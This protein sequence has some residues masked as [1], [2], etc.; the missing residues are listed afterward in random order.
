[1]II[2]TNINFIA[3]LPRNRPKTRALKKNHKRLLKKPKLM[4]KKN[5]LK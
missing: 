3:K 2:M 5:K 4:S 1:M